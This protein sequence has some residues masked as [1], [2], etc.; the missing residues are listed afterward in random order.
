MTLPS[1]FE[2]R[3]TYT[4][5]DK[6]ASGGMGTIRLGLQLVARGFSRVVA[7][8]QIHAMY[9]NNQEFVAMFRDELRVASRVVHPNVVP[10]LDVMSMDDELSLVMEYVHGLS[11]ARLLTS[12]GN[13]PSP[14]IATTI[15]I[16]MLHGLHAAHEA[17]SE[18]GDCLNIV[19]RDVTPHNVMVG[20]D[21]TPRVLDFGIAHALGRSRTTT[22]G[23]IKGKARY[24][25]PE[26]LTGES[27][28]R[29]AD[30]YSACVVFWEMLT[31]R[32][33]FHSGKDDRVIDLTSRN[34]VKSPHLIQPGISPH[35]SA[36][37]LRGLQPD[38]EARYATALE[39]AM[40]LEEGAA[41]VSATKVGQWVSR[42]WGK[43]GLARLQRIRAIE[44]GVSGAADPDDTGR[45][46]HDH[47]QTT[48]NGEI[49]ALA[50]SSDGQTT[51][52]GRLLRRLAR[53]PDAGP[54]ISYGTEDSPFGPRRGLPP[55]YPGR[56]PHG[57]Q[58]ETPPAVSP[59]PG[60]R[61]VSPDRMRGRVV[62]LA[63]FLVPLGSALALFLMRGAGLPASRDPMVASGDPPANL[64]TAPPAHVSTIPVIEKA[65]PPLSLPLAL[66]GGPASDG[67][68]PGDAPDPARPVPPHFSVGMPASD[69]RVAQAPRR[70]SVS[71]GGAKTRGASRITGSRSRPR[72]SPRTES[73]EAIGKAVEEAGAAQPPVLAPPSCDPPYVIGD[74]GIKRF[75]VACL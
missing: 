54:A 60:N 33:L 18:K 27:I 12:A 58:D 67:P 56:G 32:P 25:A 2:T 4:I 9:A 14:E 44:S 34:S 51:V 13:A 47:Q 16:G 22:V 31:G 37:V 24:L 53:K 10:I 64:P 15:V 55:P 50:E 30:I 26:Q 45:R 1:G 8:K 20:V 62:A 38:P 59:W 42:A 73:T 71:V 65:T 36:I 52:P 6:I 21:G 5:H 41:T 28:D 72:K 75:K 23:Q 46:G 69:H 35:L 19:H 39:M 17:L 63:A 68:S 57:Q 61:P 49:A 70:R 48:V 40:A 11:V 66:D 43:A 29:R 7:I 74:D 3:H